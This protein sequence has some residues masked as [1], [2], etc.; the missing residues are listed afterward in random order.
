MSESVQATVKR[1]Y[2]TEDYDQM[3]A[4]IETLNNLEIPFTMTFQPNIQPQSGFILHRWHF[5]LQVAG[6]LLGPERLMPREERT[7]DG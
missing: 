3:I 4:T 1:V 2:A 6:E 7:L 5:E